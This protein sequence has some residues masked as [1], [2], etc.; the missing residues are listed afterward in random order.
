MQMSMKPGVG[1]SDSIISV[2]SARAVATVSSLMFDGLLAAVD[3]I[4]AAGAEVNSNEVKFDAEVCVEKNATA[5][6]A[7]PTFTAGGGSSR[8]RGT[9]SKAGGV[10]EEER[11]SFALFSLDCVLKEG[12]LKPS[13]TPFGKFFS[14]TLQSRISSLNWGH[15]GGQHNMEIGMVVKT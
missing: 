1:R 2:K 14:R 13:S 11:S 15:H 3:S 12:F 8:T 7:L 6:E 9:G 4:V 5:A 10:V